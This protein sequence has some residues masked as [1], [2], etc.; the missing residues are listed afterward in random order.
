MRNGIPAAYT[1]YRSWWSFIHLALVACVGGL[2]TTWF[3][4]DDNGLRLLDRWLFELGRIQS[5]I[6]SAIPFP[7]S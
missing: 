5:V 7:W 3:V 4:R 2:A 6:A 1:A